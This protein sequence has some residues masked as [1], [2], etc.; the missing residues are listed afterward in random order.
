MTQIKLIPETSYR[1]MYGDVD[2]G[3]FA[4]TSEW[5][6]LTKLTGTNGQVVIVHGEGNSFIDTLFGDSEKMA[7][8]VTT[9]PFFHEALKKAVAK[10][11]GG[12]EQDAEKQT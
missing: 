2:L 8:V 11:G 1:V 5:N 10:D 6:G 9:S 12:S 7:T 4:K 3:V